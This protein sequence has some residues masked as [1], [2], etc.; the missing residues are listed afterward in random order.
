[1][2]KAPRD[3]LDLQSQ[4][5]VV[6]TACMG[7]KHRAAVS[8]QKRGRGDFP[9]GPRITWQCRDAGSLP[10]RAIKIP[11]VRAKLSPCAARTE[12]ASHNESVHALRQKIPRSHVMRKTPRAKLRPDTAKK[13][14]RNTATTRHSQTNKLKKKKKVNEFF[15]FKEKKED[16]L[17]SAFLINTLFSKIMI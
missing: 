6:A 15:L 17:M 16:G 2:P 13:T 14:N 10:G 7:E 3:Q 8:Y 12:P 11:H 5:S 9:G 1:M 4:S